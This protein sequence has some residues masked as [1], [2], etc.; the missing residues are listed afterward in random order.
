MSVPVNHRA[1]DDPVRPDPVHE[2]LGTD[3]DV[4]AATRGQAILTQAILAQ[5]GVASLDDLVRPDP[6][7]SARGDGPPPADRPA[8]RPAAPDPLE[9]ADGL[10]GS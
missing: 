7:V 9:P 10:V 3:E 1:Q 2:R 8:D 6:D 5:A 4:A